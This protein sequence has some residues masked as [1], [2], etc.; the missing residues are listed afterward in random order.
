[1]ISRDQSDK[2]G[3]VWLP[4]RLTGEFRGEAVVV[5][6]ALGDGV[7]EEHDAVLHVSCHDVL[8]WQEG[9]ET[10]ENRTGVSASAAV[11]SVR[12]KV[13]YQGQRLTVNRQ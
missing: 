11:P 10:E 13:T 3:I 4:A 5:V 12:V 9:Q 7:S 6:S 1:M 2:D 8:V